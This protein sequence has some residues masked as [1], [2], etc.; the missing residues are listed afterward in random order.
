MR[1]RV[2]REA[3]VTPLNA[4]KVAPAA[5]YEIPSMDEIRSV[6][7]NGLTVVSTFTGCGGSCLGFR[8]AGFRSLWANEFIP[9][10]RHV[11]Q[12]NFPDVYCD[13]RDVREIAP[14][15][16][17]ER[18]ELEVGALDVLEGSPPCA[19]FSTAGKRA[20]HWGEVV[21]YSETQQRVDDL[22]FEYVRL[23]EGL[24]PRVF[25]AENTSGLIKGVAKGYFKEILSRMKAAGYRVRAKLLDAQWLDVPQHRE[26]LIFMGVREDLERKPT[27]PKP[28]P[29]RYTLRDA[30]PW[31]DESTESKSEIDQAA[32]LT[33]TAKGDEYKIVGYWR[34]LNL[35]DGDPHKFN[36]I[37]CHPDRPVPTV[38]QT[39]GA[40][41]AATVLHPF[42]VRRFTMRE[43]RRICG[44]PEDFALDSGIAKTTPR[45]E[46]RRQWER[47][48]RA[49][50][51]PM[52][53]H[54]AETIRDEIL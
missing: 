40:A 33:E 9:A 12:T 46:F 52:M 32:W 4:L 7:D 8:W 54:V 10:A 37:K 18:C 15:E 44:F 35:G 22:F 28:L 42:E 25:I 27:Y 6:P 31:I 13:A 39:G 26:R 23:I 53:R 50:P 45:A 38:L 24:K 5:T 29:Y 3:S 30:C 48:G 19:S 20:K 1:V 34:R 49:V 47:L 16:I 14:E 21:K 41:G 11:Y 17:L 43:L 51:P 36:L 2:E